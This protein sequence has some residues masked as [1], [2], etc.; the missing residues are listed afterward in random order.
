MLCTADRAHAD[1]VAQLCAA[2]WTNYHNRSSPVGVSIYLYNIIIARW[3]S[4][5]Q[6]FDTFSLVFCAGW[7][8][9]VI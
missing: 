3:G 8:G 5:C 2:F 1:A 7:D 4:V 6:D 9:F